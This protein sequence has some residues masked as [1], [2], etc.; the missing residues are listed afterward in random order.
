[1]NLKVRREESAPPTTVHILGRDSDGRVVLGTRTGLVLL[2]QQTLLTV[3]EYRTVREINGAGLCAATNAAAL[4]GA[5][6]D[7]SVLTVV[8]W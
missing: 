7:L 5:D 1:M 2:D 4:I 8:R 6:E 3:A